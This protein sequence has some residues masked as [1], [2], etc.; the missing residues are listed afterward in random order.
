M[1]LVDFEGLKVDASLVDLEKW[2]GCAWVLRDGSVIAVNHAGHYEGARRHSGKST[3]Y[4]RDFADEYKALHVGSW[5]YAVHTATRV[6][7]DALVTL[8]TKFKHIKHWIEDQDWMVQNENDE[9]VWAL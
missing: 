4:S 2:D 9:P 3:M 1:E 6:Q 5:I 8:A 7:K